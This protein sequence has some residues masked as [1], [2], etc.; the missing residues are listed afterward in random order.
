[1]VR[2]DT[3][4]KR[5]AGVDPETRLGPRDYSEAT[6]RRTYSA[7]YDEARAALAAGRTVIADAVFA[8]PEERAAIASIA[9]DARVPFQ[10]L[11]LDA[12]PPLLEERVR[13]RLHNVSDATPEVVRLQLSFDLGPIEWPRLDSSG[14]GS[15]TLGAAGVIL[16]LEIPEDHQGL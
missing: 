10:G 13:S 3:T 7:I 2:T 1:V 11:W 9:A 8:R 14:A 6:N 5:L 4:R 16:G 12:A 15:Q